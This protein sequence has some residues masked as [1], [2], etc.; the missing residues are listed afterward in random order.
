MK[1]LVAV[2]M[3][4]TLACSL[5]MFAGCGED[6]GSIGRMDGDFST[7]ATDEEFA[8]ALTKVQGAVEGNTIL[9]GDTEAADWSFGFDAGADVSF[10]VT[11]TGAQDT[12]SADFDLGAG[13]QFVIGGAGLAGAGD[14]SV[15]GSASG[16]EE[17]SYE[18]GLYNDLN[19]MYFDMS[20]LQDGAKFKMSWEN[21]INAADGLSYIAAPH[22]EAVLSAAADTGTGG[23]GQESDSA[24]SADFA[25]IIA[26]LKTMGCKVYIDDSDGLKVK[27]SAS[28]DTADQI[29]AQ[30]GADLEGI[31]EM[32]DFTAFK[33][34]LYF[35]MTA[36]GVFSQVSADF[37][38]GMN[39][40][41]G[42]LGSY[43]FVFS[44]GIYV[45]A[46]G[47]EVELP[48]D[49]SSYIEQ[50]DIPQIPAV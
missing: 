28:E 3:S 36:D 8:E 24:I 33:F 42:E 43:E 9:G 11:V 38:I 18:I 19:Y 12:S 48:G 5:V 23:E 16:Q 4:T 37:D 21:L 49:L 17:S 15:K 30:A 13:Y 26:G 1:K 39:M 22:S 44:G 50:T 31:S 10:G 27:M 2:L 29:L 6:G 20:S 47:G 25:E 40:D 14:L 45:K 35:A 46:Y 7:E 41:L 32:I 34:D